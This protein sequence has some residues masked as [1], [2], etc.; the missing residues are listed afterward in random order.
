M[1]RTLVLIVHH[2]SLFRLGVRSALEASQEIEVV[3]ECATFADAA[4]AASQLRPDLIVLNTDGHENSFESLTTIKNQFPD[5][6][7]LAITSAIHSARTREAANFGVHGFISAQADPDQV[8][9]AVE[10]IRSGRWF[11][12]PGVAGELIELIRGVPDERLL[13]CDERYL[14]LTPREREVFKRLALGKSNKEI[15]YDLRLGRKTIET[16]HLHIMNKLGIHNPAALVR[17]AARLGVVDLISGSS[18]DG[19]K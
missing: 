19:V 3:G 18:S 1:A 5:T 11:V 6:R 10:A 12:D 7:Y 8:R 9:A 15:A 17:Y 16:H 14:S 13:G 2:C 4:G